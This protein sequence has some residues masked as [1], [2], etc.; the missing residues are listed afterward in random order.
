MSRSSAR[1]NVPREKVKRQ[2]AGK[3]FATASQAN[4]TCP[5]S[6]RAPM[7]RSTEIGNDIICNL[8]DSTI[9][10]RGFAVTYWTSTRALRYQSPCLQ[11]SCPSLRE[12]NPGFLFTL[13]RVYRFYPQIII[14]NR[15]S[16]LSPDIKSEIASLQFSKTEGTACFYLIKKKASNF[17]VCPVGRLNVDLWK[18]KK[19]GNSPRWQTHTY[20]YR[21]HG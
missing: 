19:C 10:E 1:R 5:R 4:L 20:L 9:R 2:R 18:T 11:A 3:S 13:V 7:P 17:Q 12:L 16:K 15:E 8:L 14:Y 6:D 21:P